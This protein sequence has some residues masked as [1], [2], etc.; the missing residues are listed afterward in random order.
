MHFHMFL[1]SGLGHYAKKNL[2]QKVD[3]GSSS[4]IAPIVSISCGY[5]HTIILTKLG[6]LFACGSNNYGQLGVGIDSCQHPFQK[7][8]WKIGFV[9]SVTCGKYH[10]VAVTRSGEIYSWG[11]NAFKQLGLGDKEN[12]NY[13]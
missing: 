8:N 5:T 11:Y 2:P 1:Q 13:P 7:L 9:T 6:E 12:R 10:T 4:I 3:L